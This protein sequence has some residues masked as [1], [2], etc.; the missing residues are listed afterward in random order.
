MKRFLFSALAVAL[1][2][3]SCEKQSGVETPL[4]SGTEVAVSVNMTEDAAVTRADEDPALTYYLEAYYRETSTDDYVLYK[5]YTPQDN[6]QFDIR[7][8][9]GEDFMLVAWADYDGLENSAGGCYNTDD[10]CNITVN[11][12]DMAINNE[13]RD[14]FSFYRQLTVTSTTDVTMTLTRPFARINVIATDLDN[15]QELFKPTMSV[16]TYTSEIYTAFDAMTGVASELKTVELAMEEDFYSTDGIFTFDYIL[17]PLDDRALVDFNLDFYKDRA[18]GVEGTYTTSYKLTNIPYERNYQTNITGNLFTKEGNID[19]TIDDEWNTPDLNVYMTI[20]DVQE[21]IGQITEGSDTDID[22]TFD[23]TDD[24]I[25]IFPS[26][27]D[28]TTSVSLTIYGEIAEGVTLALDCEGSVQGDYAGEFEVTFLKD[29]EGGF[30]ASLFKS[31]PFT[32]NGPGSVG[33]LKTYVVGT[34]DLSEGFTC[35]TYEANS[36]TTYNYGTILETPGSTAGTIYIVIGEG[37]DRET[38]TDVQT[39]I[40]TYLEGGTEASGKKYYKGVVLGDT[41]YFKDGSTQEL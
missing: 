19:I 8:V 31:T 25:I 22:V 17:A 3:T 39:A 27:M 4:E 30:S 1:L 11:E 35:G 6:G 20:D 36:G 32:V 24:A 2:A 34:V 10:L 29:S 9:T 37:S 21:I 5:R 18:E 38:E 13:L 26:G 7:L 23:I 40:D 14:A 12:S 28:A 33:S 16:W 41:I 15:V